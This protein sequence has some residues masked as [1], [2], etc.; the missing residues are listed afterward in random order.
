MI[1]EDV[2]L[3]I[4]RKH[5]HP[6]PTQGLP[7]KAVYRGNMVGVRYLPPEAKSNDSLVFFTSDVSSRS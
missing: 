5:V 4:V 3:A 6:F 1:Q 2:D 7:L